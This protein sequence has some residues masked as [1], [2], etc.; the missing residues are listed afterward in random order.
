MNYNLPTLG[1]RFDINKTDNADY[2]GECWK[3]FWRAIDIQK[4]RGALL[5]EG[6]TSASASG[7]ENVYCIA[8][9]STN[10]AVLSDIQTA[11]EQSTEFQKI[12]SSPKFATGNS[13]I[14]EPLIATGKVDATGELI[15]GI[16]SKSALEVIKIEKKDKRFSFSDPELVPFKCMH[17]I[18]RPAL[19]LRPLPADVKINIRRLVGQEAQTEK[20]DARVNM[21]D[22]FMLQSAFFRLVGDQFEWIGE[23]EIYYGPNSKGS[24]REDITINY[25]VKPIAN[26]QEGYSVKYYGP[27]EQLSS[28][29]PLTLEDARPMLTRWGAKR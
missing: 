19:G 1:I 4:I 2:G 11:L 28:R 13:V 23:Q 29:Q 7:K 8:I 25:F 27:D 24:R 15:G 5:F 21:W 14:R 22:G 26:E 10:N 20:Y 9:Q 18:D 3:I 16:N 12:A 17:D 6:D